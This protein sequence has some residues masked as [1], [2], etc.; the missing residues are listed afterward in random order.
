[1][2][3]INVLK[4][5]VNGKFVESKTNDFLDVEN[6][7]T[8]KI[9]AKVPLSTKKELDEAVKYAKEAFEKWKNISPLKRIQ[10]LFKLK[11]LM[12][13]KQ[14]E[15]SEI[16]TKEHGKFYDESFLE[17]ERAIENVEVATGVP[18]LMQGNILE[19]IADGIDEYFIR[20]PIGVF[21]VI[22]PFNFPAMIPFWFLPYAVACG[23]TFIVKPSEQVPC[24]QQFIFELIDKAGFPDGVLGLINGD[25]NLSHEMIKH[26]DIVG[27]SSVTSTP[28]AKEIY[29]LAA[30]YGKRVQCQAGA[31]NS[32]II[33][34]DAN[35]EKSISNIISSVYGNTGQRCLAVSNIIVIGNNYDGVRAKL[36]EAAKKLK[37]GDGLDKDVTM[38]P[39]I[40]ADAKKKIEGYIEKGLEEGAKLTLDGR[41]IKVKG[42]EKGHFLGPCIFEDV[43]PEMAIAQEEIFGPVLTLI[44]E[45]SLKNAIKN[46]NKGRY[47]NAAAI[48]TSNG[49]NA[50]EFQNKVDC[51]NIGINI[52][53]AAPIGCFPFCGK[54]D[55][56]FGDIHGQSMDAINFYTDKK[57]VI[58]R[59]Y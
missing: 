32:A 26:P 36:M 20:K 42:N 58:Q 50:R 15:I 12:E 48:Y 6:P 27:I 8:G 21:C 31:K 28:V 22:P 33:M 53:V 30:E 45:K 19:N 59:W 10:Y 51:G 40:S 56:F 18:T 41:G 25:K 5:Y 35:L 49:K 24:T 29:K 2:V 34:D 47:G 39:V 11:Q 3:I 52:G 17:V 57:V 13:E 9:I 55:S 37:V 4:N 1:V 43:K 14:K 44:K 16:L 46:I 54:K 23:N 7:A 38:G